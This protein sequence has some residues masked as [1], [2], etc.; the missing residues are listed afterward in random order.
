MTETFTDRLSVERH[1][2]LLLSQVAE[3]LSGVEGDQ[4]LFPVGLPAP[5]ARSLSFAKG[6]APGLL[7]APAVPTVQTV[8]RDI[9]RER[10]RRIDS[11]FTFM[12]HRFQ[13]RPSDR[14]NIMGAAQLAV[15]AIGQGAEP[16]NLRWANP[17]QDFVW[18]TAD[19]QLVPLDAYQVLALFQAGVAFKSALTFHARG[20]KDAAAEAEDL[21]AFEWRNGWPE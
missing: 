12:G 20:L 6:T 7:A 4:S 2:G 19:N 21:T 13:S 16:G 14:E 17:D 8:S 18:I 10:D 5:L 15:G 1:I 3:A 9:D 11:G